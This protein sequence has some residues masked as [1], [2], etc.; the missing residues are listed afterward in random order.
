LT[1][2]YNGSIFKLE[3]KGPILY[4]IPALKN[5]ERM[6]YVGY[7]AIKGNNKLSFLKNGDI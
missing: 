4:Y 7:K 5:K 3:L 2:A 6:T 1:L